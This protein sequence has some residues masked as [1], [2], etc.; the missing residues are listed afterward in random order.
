MAAMNNKTQNRRDDIES[1]YFVLAYVAGFTSPFEKKKF[2]DLYEQKEQFSG[3]K[4]YLVRT[5]SLF[6]LL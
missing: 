6:M 4:L 1:L 5:H 3:N 2:K